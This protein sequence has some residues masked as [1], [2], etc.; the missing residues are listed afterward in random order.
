MVILVL[1][2][3]TE[4]RKDKVLQAILICVLIVNNKIVI[5]LT[6]SSI[7]S[8][9]LLNNYSLRFYYTPGIVLRWTNAGMHKTNRCLT[10]LAYSLEMIK[11]I[12]FTGISL[13]ANKYLL[14]IHSMPDT[15]NIIMNQKDIVHMLVDLTIQQI[16]QIQSNHCI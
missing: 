3:L 12:G 10:S 8:S 13:L 4:R 14:S 16:R 5:Q 15:F 1:K 11:L 6:I 2:R 9:H 7:V